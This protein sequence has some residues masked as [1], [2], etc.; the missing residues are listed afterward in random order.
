[1]VAFVIRDNADLVKGLTQREI[2]NLTKEDCNRAKNNGDWVW[3]Y[4]AE[5]FEEWL[6]FRKQDPEPMKRFYI[7]IFD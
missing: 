4:D 6:R 7:R 5:Q 1:M 2:D 3:R